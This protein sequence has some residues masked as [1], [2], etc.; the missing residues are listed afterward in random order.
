MRTCTLSLSLTHTQ[1]DRSCQNT[2]ESRYLSTPVVVTA[3]YDR[4]KMTYESGYKLWLKASKVKPFNLTPRTPLAR[5]AAASSS[6]SSSSW[7]N[8]AQIEE[9]CYV[10][11]FESIVINIF[12]HVK[13]QFHKFWL[14]GSGYVCLCTFFID[15]HDFTMY[16]CVGLSNKSYQYRF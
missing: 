13:K 9:W 10:S 4:Y 6:S 16:S 8:Y 12:T 15:F 11:C 1:L 7:P 14:A 2:D 3:E 5:R